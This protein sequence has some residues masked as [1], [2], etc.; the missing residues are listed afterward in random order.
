MC[1]TKGPGNVV[2]STPEP[3]SSRPPLLRVSNVDCSLE[4]RETNSR[5]SSQ[6]Q[7]RKLQPPAGNHALLQILTDVLFASI[8]NAHFSLIFRRFSF[9]RPR[10]I[11]PP[12]QP[13]HNKHKRILFY[14]AKYAQ[15]AVID[16]RFRCSSH[17]NTH[18]CAFPASFGPE[19]ETATRGLH[20]L[21]RLAVFRLVQAQRLSGGRSS[22]PG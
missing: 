6:N 18:Q 16:C 19:I 4:Q 12:Q 13:K 14:R 3:N 20:G 15:N 11:P 21:L 2:T 5:S 22:D 7:R 17:L 8:E 9:R 10:N 1:S